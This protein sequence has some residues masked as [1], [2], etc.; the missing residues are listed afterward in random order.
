MVLPEMDYSIQ[1]SMWKVENLFQESVLAVHI[2]QHLQNLVCIFFCDFG[3]W[4]DWKE[5]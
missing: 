4:G 3:L 1:P 2:L 5:G